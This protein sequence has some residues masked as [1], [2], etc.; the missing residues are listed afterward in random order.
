MENEICSTLLSIGCVKEF[1]TLTA[2]IIATFAAIVSAMIVWAAAKLPLKHQEKLLN[3]K[4]EQKLKYT[5]KTLCHDYRKT[6][7]VAKQ[8]A[9]TIKLIS[10]TPS[11]KITDDTR[12]KVILKTPNLAE[13]WEYVSLLEEE[14]FDAINA[15]DKKIYEHNFDMMR[16]RGN[17][18]DDNFKKI[19]KKRADEIGVEAFELSNL[20]NK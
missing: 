19:V 15:L 17:F 11:A 9:S 6:S 2:S 4:S 14:L 20:F 7:F 13:K 10:V 5:K 3:E 12:D 18:G 8:A 1:Q 16:A